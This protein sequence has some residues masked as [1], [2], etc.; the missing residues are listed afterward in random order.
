[1]AEGDTGKQ[2]NIYVKLVI[3][4]SV[5]RIEHRVEPM[6]NRQI[7]IN[8]GLCCPVKLYW[9]LYWRIWASIAEGEKL[10]GAA[11]VPVLLRGFLN[12]CSVDN[13]N[14][15]KE[16]RWWKSC[17]RKEELW[18]YQRMRLWKAKWFVHS[19]VPYSVTATVSKSG[20]RFMCQSCWK[21]S[22]AAHKPAWHYKLCVQPSP[23]CWFT[24]EF[25]FSSSWWI[26]ISQVESIANSCWIAITAFFL[27]I[28]GGW[29]FNTHISLLI[30]P[31]PAWP[32]ACASSSALRKSI[33][34]RQLCWYFCAIHFTQTSSGAFQRL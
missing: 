8:V 11:A 15:A 2:P 5:S 23:N 17:R 1:M 21:R 32:T 30:L 10:K 24:V 29:H 28:F 27:W 16:P 18:T 6:V 31:C 9:T 12:Y 26:V 7:S 25:S 20:R 4:H 13:P 19:N 33:D 22:W 3:C 14:G 34:F